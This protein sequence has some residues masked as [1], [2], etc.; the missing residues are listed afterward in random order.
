MPC[1]SPSLSLTLTSTNLVAHSLLDRLASLSSLLD[2]DP[3]DPS[4]LPPPPS[5]LSVS[6]E[7]QEKRNQLSGLVDSVEDRH[8]DL[9]KSL[10]LIDQMETKIQDSLISEKAKIIEEMDQKRKKIDQRQE[11]LLNELETKSKKKLERLAQQR[12]RLEADLSCLEN[13]VKVSRSFLKN[14][15]DHQLSSHLHLLSDQLTRL[16]EDK[17]LLQPPVETT[18]LE[19]DEGQPIDLLDL[20]QGIKLVEKQ[21]QDLSQDLKDLGIPSAIDE[22]ERIAAQ[23][24]E[25]ARKAEAERIAAEE[26]ARLAA[27][28]TPRDYSSIGSPSLVFGSKGSGIGQFNNPFGVTVDLNNRNIVRAS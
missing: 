26:A 3:S 18:F 19:L 4:P 28:A 27:K 2:P 17:N 7:S 23:R 13:S 8:K 14:A 15:S 10:S 9:D 11:E 6:P 16:K 5:S 1:V 22:A 21:P 12:K 24:A 25:T 20:L